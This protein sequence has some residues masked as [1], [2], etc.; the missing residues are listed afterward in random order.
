[1]TYANPD[2]RGSLLFS[3]KR[4][5]VHEETEPMSNSSFWPR[6]TSILI[7]ALLTVTMSN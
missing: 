4:Q 1:M 2:S 5:F 3:H 6:V 7:I